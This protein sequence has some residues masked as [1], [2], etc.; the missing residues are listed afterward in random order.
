F[1]SRMGYEVLSANRI[2][3]NSQGKVVS[4]KYKPKKS[5][6]IAGV[7]ISFRKSPGAA[8]KK[9]RYFSINISNNSLKY[10]PNFEKYINS[11]EKFAATLKAASYILHYHKKFS[12]IRDIILARCD[13]ILQDD[14]GVAL[15]Y[16]KAK[17]WD[18]Q[19]FGYYKGPIP[20]FRKFHQKKLVT[21]MKKHSKGKL[22]FSYGYHFI[23]GQSNLIYARRK[24]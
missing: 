4:K 8:V 20:F 1:I 21:L 12:K 19:Y 7:E 18:I 11:H 23:P 10:F 24:Q 9:M 3:I 6:W 15:R 5:R 13:E 14:S 17:D 2:F 22:P 16:Y